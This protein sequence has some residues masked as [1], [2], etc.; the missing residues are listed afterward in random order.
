MNK[1]GR[2]LKLADSPVGDSHSFTETCTKSSEIQGRHANWTIMRQY[3]RKIRTAQQL[4]LE[5]FLRSWFRVSFSIN[6]HIKCPTR[7]NTISILLQD[8]APCFGYF[9]HPLSGVQNCSWQTLVQHIVMYKN[10]YIELRNEGDISSLLKTVS[11]QTK[12]MWLNVIWV[13][14]IINILLNP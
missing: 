4:S 12:I 1:C 7:C 10:F 2:K 3:T 5:F 6:I 14:K 8:H 13:V 11:K 9:P